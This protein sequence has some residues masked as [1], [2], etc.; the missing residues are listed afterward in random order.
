MIRDLFVQTVPIGVSL[1]QGNWEPFAGLSLR[2]PPLPSMGQCLLLPQRRTGCEQHGVLLEGTGSLPSSCPG[3]ALTRSVVPGGYGKTNTD[4]CCCS[5]EENGLLGIKTKG[6][7]EQMRG[8]TQGRG[9]CPA[10]TG[11][12]H[13][14]SPQLLQHHWYKLS[15][16]I[17]LCH[18]A[19]S[20]CVLLEAPTVTYPCDKGLVRG[21]L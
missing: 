13:V 6:G 3:T 18:H 17:Q 4:G 8:V 5:R 12:L 20:G 9:S 15:D 10:L 16:E 11:D 7:S 14:S 21:T 2:Q 1:Q 19:L